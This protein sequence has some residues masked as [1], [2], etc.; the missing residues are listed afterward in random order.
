MNVCNKFTLIIIILNKGIG[1][2]GGGSNKYK[3]DMHQ[4]KHGKQH[5][6]TTFS[7]S[8]VR[9]NPSCDEFYA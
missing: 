1:N 6:E 9:Y 8:F 5:Y 7:K 3:T 2:K 4:N